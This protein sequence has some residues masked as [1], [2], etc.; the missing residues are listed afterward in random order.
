MAFWTSG[1]PGLVG[2]VFAVQTGNRGFD[3]HRRQ[4][5]EQFSDPMDQDTR[6]QCTSAGASALLNR[7]NCTCAPRNTTNTM[8]TDERRRVGATMVPYRWATWGTS[9]RESDYNNSFL[10]WLAKFDNS[11]PHM[12]VKRFSKMRNEDVLVLPRIGFFLTSSHDKMGP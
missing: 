4:M 11:L 10:N 5:S 7:R 2:R 8:R 3:S 9:L 12:R 1:A 6:T